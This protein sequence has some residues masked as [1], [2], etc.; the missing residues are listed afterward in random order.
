MWTKWPFL[1]G[2]RD[3]GDVVG[4]VVGDVDT[5]PVISK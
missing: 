2:A 1:Y 3:T 5:H 4:D